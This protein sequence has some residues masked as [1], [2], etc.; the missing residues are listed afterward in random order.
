MLT[1]N[2]QG[3]GQQCRTCGPLAP[4]AAWA[5][6]GATQGSRVPLPANRAYGPPA[7][8]GRMGVV[9][10]HPGFF[11]SPSRIA[12]PKFQ[13]HESSFVHPARNRSDPYRHEASDVAVLRQLYKT[14]HGVTEG[15]SSG[16]AGLPEGVYRRP[17]TRSKPTL[18]P[19]GPAKIPPVRVFAPP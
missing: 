5:F 14:R 13:R 19:I 3:I 9:G 7:T 6:S 1:V 8:G 12:S 11:G 15:G 2:S 4:G 16:A 10:R 18:Y 17:V